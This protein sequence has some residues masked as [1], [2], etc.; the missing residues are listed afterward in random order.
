[1]INGDHM[2]SMQK[3]PCKLHRTLGP[4]RMPSIKDKMPELEL[5][6]LLQPHRVV[7]PSVPQWIC[8]VS[9]KDTL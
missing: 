1:M 8:L 3:I 5:L 9:A 4:P 6:W 7:A 2:R